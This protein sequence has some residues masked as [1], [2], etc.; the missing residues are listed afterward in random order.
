MKNLIFIL[1]LFFSYSATCKPKDKKPKQTK[2]QIMMDSWMNQHKSELLKVWGIPTRTSDDGQG[3]E[4]LAYERTKVFPQM[5][6]ASVHYNNVYSTRTQNVV[7]R[8]RSFYVNKDGIVYSW[9]CNGRVG[10]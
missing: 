4:I 5:G 1:I 10:Y 8:I 7:T 2:E 3:G 6:V 9:L